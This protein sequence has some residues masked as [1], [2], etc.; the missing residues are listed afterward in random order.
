VR[1][2]K[3]M[4]N[5]YIVADKYSREGYQSWS[6]NENEDETNNKHESSPKCEAIL[7][8]IPI[9]QLTKGIGKDTKS[10]A[11]LGDF[12]NWCEQ[13]NITLLVTYPSVL[14]HDAYLLP[15]TQK[16]INQVDE[17]WKTKGIKVL[18]KY[19]EFAYEPEYVHDTAYHLNDL[20]MEKRTR[21]LI[22]Y[23]KNNI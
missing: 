7:R 2:A 12:S 5:K 21:L 1:L 17:F 20:G 9:E 6:L 4:K 19:N 11:L 23:L 22:D 18:G 15:N 13:N 8:Y 14:R 3:G 10:W 16:T